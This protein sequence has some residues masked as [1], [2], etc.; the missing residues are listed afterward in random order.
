MG[1]S[2][3]FLRPIGLEGLFAFAK[4]LL[5]PFEERDDLG[6]LKFITAETIETLPAQLY[7]LVTKTEAVLIQT[8]LD[9]V[10]RTLNKMHVLKEKVDSDLKI[11]KMLAAYDELI[12]NVKIA[13][14][15]SKK[16]NGDVNQKKQRDLIKILC[17]IDVYTC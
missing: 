4:Q 7:A 11:L 16:S 10:D 9:R 8:L 14:N 13:K 3:T 2:E 15:Q 12:S 17:K 5:D 6:N 1:S